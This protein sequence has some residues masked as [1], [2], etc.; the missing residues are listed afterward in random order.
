LGVKCGGVGGLLE[1]FKGAGFAEEDAGVVGKE[2]IGF[3]EAFERA[4]EITHAIEAVGFRDKC[5]DAKFES[6]VGLGAIGGGW[7]SALGLGKLG[8]R[9]HAGDGRALDDLLLEFREEKPSYGEELNDEEKAENADGDN[10]CRADGLA[11]D[12]RG[13]LS[14]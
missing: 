6:R 9:R 10:E 3:V 11:W 13:A 5:V 1:T 7:S 2:A 12:G 14:G 8:C 4:V